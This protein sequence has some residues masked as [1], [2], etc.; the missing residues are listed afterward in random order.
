MHIFPETTQFLYS[1]SKQNLSVMYVHSS[2]ASFTIHS[3]TYFTWADESLQSIE[4][5]LVNM[6][7]DLPLDNSSGYLSV[8]TLGN[9][10]PYATLDHCVLPK[11]SPPL[12][13]MM[14]HF[15]WFLFPILFS[16]LSQ[17]VYAISFSKGSCRISCRP[18]FSS[19]L[20]PLLVI[21]KFYMALYTIWKWQWKLLS[22]VWLFAKPWAIQSMESPCQNTG[23]GSHI[24]SVHFSLSVV[25]DS[26]WPQEPQH[27]RSPCPSSTPRVHPNSCPS[28]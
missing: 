26:L 18:L 20:Y 8:F 4:M 21:L 7:K 15:S 17:S 11:I 9:L 25:S 19:L 10:S 24:I 14:P 12:V 1:P 16:I 27:T 23:V 13:S 28:S 5:S 3:F 6:T 2:S 22:C